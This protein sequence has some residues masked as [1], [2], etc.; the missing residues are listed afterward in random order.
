MK[1]FRKSITE[2]GYPYEVL[3]IE[4]TFGK[5]Q[6]VPTDGWVD[7]HGC[8]MKFHNWCVPTITDLKII[9][10][11]GPVASRLSFAYDKKTE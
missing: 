6:W 11:G 7:I 8:L 10:S 5:M 4:P 9:D 2:N 3:L 1:L